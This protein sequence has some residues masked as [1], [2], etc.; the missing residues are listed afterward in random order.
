MNY[1]QIS[2]IVSKEDWFTGEFNTLANIGSHRTVTLSWG[3]KRKDSLKSNGPDLSLCVG[4]VV[5]VL[6]HGTKWT[7]TAKIVSIDNSTS[8][9]TVKWHSTGMKDRVNLTDCVKW[10]QH[11]TSNRKRTLTDFYQHVPTKK[12]NSDASSTTAL[13]QMKNMFYSKDNCLKLC[14]EGAIRNLMNMLHCS[15]KDM[16]SFWDLALSP[17]PSLYGKNLRVRVEGWNSTL[18]RFGLVKRRVM[19]TLFLYQFSRMH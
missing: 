16:N 13:D 1:N 10:D 9:A 18:S 8:L 4:D 19:K 6:N 15:A 14:V 3:C 2:E 17:L 7:H 11:G 5:N 12:Q